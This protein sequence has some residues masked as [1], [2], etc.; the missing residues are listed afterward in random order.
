MHK[1][2]FKDI[3]KDA[4]KDLLR[5]FVLR[6]KI[7]L[8]SR[9]KIT[10]PVGF[11]EI[12]QWFIYSSIRD[13]WLHDIGFEFNKRSF[14]L[15]TFSSILQRGRY[16]KEKNLFVFPR[17]ISFIVASPVDWI[18][19]KLASGSIQKDKIN[20]WYNDVYLTE[21]SVLKP[22]KVESN[23]ILVRA[24]T[25]IE[26]HSTFETQ[27]GKKTHYYTPFESEFSSLIN[28]NA[29]KKWKAFFKSEPPSDIKIEPK[30][31]NKEKIVRFGTDER[32][33]IVKGWTG[34]FKLQGEP[35]FL[36][37]ILDA[38]IGSRNPQG[39]GLVEVMNEKR[40]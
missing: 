20:M 33:V 32:Y 30:G 37:F 21:I 11:N 8:E 22:N 29:R 39:F 1:I 12:L 28:E 15:F 17:R 3:L 16:L 35:D 18:L 5:V 36:K 34:N 7:T 26:V 19:Q 2:N 24:L 25:P 4:Q 23:T 9:D 27:N 31:F 14:K 10:L 13:E 40:D 38:G 6:I